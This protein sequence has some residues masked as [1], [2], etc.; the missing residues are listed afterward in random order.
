MTSIDSRGRRIK[1]PGMI[2]ALAIQSRV[3]N[4][5]VMREFAN[6]FGKQGTGL[7]FTF[8][9]PMMQS[10]VIALMRY[11]LGAAGYGGMAVFPFTL[12]GV[13]YVRAFTLMD[14]SLMDA[15]RNNR[16]L[17]YFH[18]VS[19]LDIYLSKFVVGLSVN[20]MVGVILYIA[21]RV[22][23]LAPPAQEPFY[24][25]ILLITVNLF[26]FGWGL[27]LASLALLFPKLQSVNRI[28]NRLLYFTSGIF[29]AVPE[30]PPSLREYLLYNPLLHITEL[31]RSYYFPQY[32][33][34]YASVGYVAEWLVLVLVAGLL[35]E[36]MFRDRLQR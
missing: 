2:Q 20:L 35:L 28:L 1:K 31:S 16:G 3:L 11:I 33:S 18:P 32:D 4:G 29:F 7:A 12:C 5:L 34:A 22:S 8:I 23:G 26:G 27:A 25:L 24:L 19:E 21:M 13:L 17:L 14:S 36:R 9:S 15:L 30:V 6:Q 10:A